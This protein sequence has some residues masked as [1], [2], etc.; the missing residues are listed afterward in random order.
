MAGLILAPRGCGSA[1][2][3]GGTIDL[4]EATSSGAAPQPLDVSVDPSLPRAGQWDKA[5]FQ[6]HGGEDMPRERVARLGAAISRRVGGSDCGTAKFGDEGRWVGGE[7]ARIRGEAARRSAVGGRRNKPVSMVP[8]AEVGRLT[9]S[10]RPCRCEPSTTDRPGECSARRT[11]RR[12]ASGFLRSPRSTED[13]SSKGF[14]RR[15]TA[16]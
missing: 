1:I 8:K 12:H 16:E 5:A 9:P 6:R 14:R 10:V 2:S 7:A 13:A 11:M 15:K 4:G 3:K